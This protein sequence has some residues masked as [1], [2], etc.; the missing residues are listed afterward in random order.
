MQ[1]IDHHITIEL[2]HDLCSAVLEPFFV[3][4]RPPVL[5]IA[6]CIEFST[7]IIK[8]MGHLVPDHATD[9]AIVHGIIGLGIK[10][11]RLQNTGWKNDL[12]SG[13]TIIGIYIGRALFTFRL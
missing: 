11:W 10:E 12:I 13:R 7:L 1:V 4:G 3:L 5:Q 6:L 2:L 9:A 8:A